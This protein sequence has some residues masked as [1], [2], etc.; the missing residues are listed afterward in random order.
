M[1][2]H[3]VKELRTILLIVFVFV[4]LDLDCTIKLEKIGCF[5]DDVNKRVFPEEVCILHIFSI[6]WDVFIKLVPRTSQYNNCFIHIYKSTRTGCAS[7]FYWLQILLSC[8]HKNFYF[9]ESSAINRTHAYQIQWTLYN[10]NLYNSNLSL[11]RTISLARW[12]FPNKLS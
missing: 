12:K 4:I 11:T 2:I 10:S 9:E 8:V 6:L 5:R 1:R 7:W 3:N